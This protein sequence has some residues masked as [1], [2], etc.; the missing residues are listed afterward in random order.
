MDQKDLLNKK[1]LSDGIKL[2][3]KLGDKAIATTFFDPQYRGILDKMN[4]GNEGER[5]KGRASLPQMSEKTIINFINE[6]D[7]VTKPS[8]HLFLWID[9]FHLVE[10]ISEWMINTEFVPVD[11][12]VWN[13]KTFGMG[14][15]TRRTSEYLMVLQKKP[16]R[17]KNVWTVKNIRDVWDEKLETMHKNAHPHSK[18]IELQKILIEATV[19]HGEIV[20][21]PA[22][23]SFSVLTSAKLAGR[24]CIVND[25]EFGEVKI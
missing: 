1:I 18:P 15:R 25:I 20:L 23:G 19:K 17:A 8:G 9:K 6:I 24:D 21:D 12:I 13:K 11:L 3:S 7:R 10:G 4:Y 22:A 16:K 5:Q 14:Y 2:L